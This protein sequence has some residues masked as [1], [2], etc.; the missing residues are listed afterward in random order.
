MRPSDRSTDTL[1]WVGL[2]FCSPTTP[3]TGTRE[4]CTLQKLDGPTRNWNWRSAS[5]KG[6][7]SMSPTVP[8]SSITHT[9]AGPGLPSTG[10]WAT[11]S[12]HSWMASVMWGTTW[13][14]LPR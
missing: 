2:V 11:R 8:P 7:D 13:T 6:M 3:R 10:T 14:V 9:S 4:T 1:C 5:T 12:I